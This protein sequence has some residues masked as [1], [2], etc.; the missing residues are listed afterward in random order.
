MMEYTLV[1]RRPVDARGRRVASRGAWTVARPAISAP[2]ASASSLSAR[3][4]RE[5]AQV[6]AVPICSALDLDGAAY[7]QFLVE[8]GALAASITMLGVLTLRTAAGVDTARK[9]IQSLVMAAEV[10]H[11]VNQLSA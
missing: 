4:E 11:I 1:F 8:S 7:E 2:P 10:Q 6:F 5:V 9:E 3:T